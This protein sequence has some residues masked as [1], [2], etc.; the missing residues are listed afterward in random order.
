MSHSLNGRDPRQTLRLLFHRFAVPITGH[1]PVQ[2]LQMDGPRRTIGHR[3][4]KIARHCVT[5]S[6][7]SAPRSGSITFTK[8]LSLYP[9]LIRLV[10]TTT[11]TPVQCRLRA[12]RECGG[13]KNLI[14]AARRGVGNGVLMLLWDGI[15]VVTGD[16]KERIRGIL[17]GF[18][19]I[20]LKK[21]SFC[22]LL[23][24]IQNIAYNEI[25]IRSCFSVPSFVQ[26][27][28]HYGIWGGH[29]ALVTPTP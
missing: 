16:G 5:A 29:P 21:S 6:Q 17:D 8:A 2:Q 14:A 18:W 23:H 28:N 20:V 9:Q 15:R 13:G 10:T 12:V 1:F 7:V 11:P 27:A 22:S 24:R 26:I 19:Q 3:P 25:S 4:T